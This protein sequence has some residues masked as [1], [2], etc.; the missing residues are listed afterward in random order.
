MMASCRDCA[1]ARSGIA[2][3]TSYT[4][5]T[6][7]IIV[8][9]FKQPREK[10]YRTRL[11]TVN[12]AKTSEG[13]PCI[14]ETSPTCIAPISPVEASAQTAACQPACFNPRKALYERWPLLYQLHSRKCRFF[15]N[16]LNGVTPC[17]SASA[18]LTLS[19]PVVSAPPLVKTPV[20]IL[21]ECPACAAS[22]F[23]QVR[24]EVLSFLYGSSAPSLHCC[25]QQ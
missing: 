8:S 7:K 2:A 19:A 17:P 5:S 14:I 16:K 1:S 13:S 11:I 12:A 10:S 23:N 4:A 3:S 18:P 21:E 25:E 9:P 22:G 15:C 6:S 24:P 20:P